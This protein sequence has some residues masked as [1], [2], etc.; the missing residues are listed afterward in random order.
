MTVATEG[1]SPGD[2]KTEQ[3]HL[4]ANEDDKKSC[5]SVDIPLLFI[6]GFY[7]FFMGGVGCVLPFLSIYYKQ[8]GL[9]PQQIGLISGLRPIVGFTSGPVWGSLADRFNIHRVLLFI[10][11]LSWIGV[12]VGLAFVPPAQEISS[13]PAEL[14]PYR[15]VIKLPQAAR[16]ID[17]H[18][19]FSGLKQN[20]TH[21]LTKHEDTILK[22]NI[23]WIY[24]PDDLQR[25]FITVLM[26]ILLGE[27]VQSPT[28]ALSDTGTLR[29]LGPDRLDKY[30]NQRA[31]GPLGWA[32]T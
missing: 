22:E 28:T 16:R 7:F 20:T 12:F 30:G 26:L 21:N 32:I 6:K 18:E 14:K 29:T 4:V 11:L 19:I 31:W 1:G 3:T 5:C 8:L 15:P 2:T 9:S 25:V 17:Y 24:D 23:G 27:F 10:S 13:C